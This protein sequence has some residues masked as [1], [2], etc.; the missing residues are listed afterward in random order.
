M[1]DFYLILQIILLILAFSM[2]VATL[3]LAPW[4]PT[5]NRDLQRVFRL[6]NLSPGEV[7]YDLGSGTGTT[8]F[9]AAK[10]KDV[11]ARGIELALPLYVFSVIKKVLLGSKQASFKWKS[12]FKEDLS[13]ADVIYIFGLPNKLKDKLVNKFQKELKSGS[14]VVSYVFPIKGL[15]PVIV[16]HP[17]DQDLSVYVYKF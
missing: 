14:R 13:E 5:R 17:T 11:K 7:F 9:A 3:S 1:T 8:V 2:V 4:V 16:D 10:I 15:E 6:S 12:L